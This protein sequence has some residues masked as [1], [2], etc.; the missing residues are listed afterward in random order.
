MK[1]AAYRNRNHTN[2]AATL[3]ALGGV[4]RLEDDL[5]EAERHLLEALDMLRAVHGDYEHSNIVATLWALGGV[6]QQAGDL[7]EAK[8]RRDDALEMKLALSCLFSEAGDLPK[9]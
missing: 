1:R 9:A 8:K 2:I 7:S 5:S 3:H 4:C 6:H